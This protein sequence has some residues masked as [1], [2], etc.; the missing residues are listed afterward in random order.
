MKIDIKRLNPAN[1][2]KHDSADGSANLTS[3]RDNQGGQY[4]SPFASDSLWSMHREVDR[5]F[6]NMFSRIGVG[7]PQLFGDELSG[8]SVAT[9]RPNV[10][11]RETKK[12]YKISVEIPGVEEK[13]MALEL[14]NG[15]LIIKGEKKH[16]KNEDEEGHYWIER[17]YGSFSR[18]LSL[19]DDAEYDKIEAGFKS[20]VLT[21]TVPR[22][23]V[24]KSK[25]ET[26]VIEIKHAA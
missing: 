11:I 17:S 20:G 25:D 2:F 13:D 22:K 18:T 19:P 7:L 12:E 10:D 4:L 9:L 16:E 23:H 3:R 5:L 21:I 8:S 6:D 26:K 1:W 14:V 15:E 24:A